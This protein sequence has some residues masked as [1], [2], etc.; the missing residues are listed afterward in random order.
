MSQISIRD[1]P[2]GIESEIRR[3]A[4]VNHISLSKAILLLLQKALGF[5]SENSKKRDLSC[6]FGTWSEAEYHEFHRN[7]SQ[8]EDIDE[9]I[10]E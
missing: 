9:E 8:F 3:L 6:V 1:I 7:T 2:E 4:S 10:W 5:D